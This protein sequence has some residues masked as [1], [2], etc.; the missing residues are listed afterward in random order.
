MPKDAYDPMEQNN[1]E[2]PW[3][4]IT[5][6]RPG[7]LDQPDGDLVSRANMPQVLDEDGAFC[8]D[9]TARAFSPATKVYHLCDLGTHVGACGVHENLVVFGYAALRDARSQYKCTTRSSF[10]EK[11]LFQFSCPDGATGCCTDGGPGSIGDECYY[12]TSSLCPKRRFAFLPDEA[13]PDVP[14]DSCAVGEVTLMDGTTHSYGANNDVCEDG[15]M[16]S[17]F[18]P[19]RNPCQPNTDV[20]HE[21]EPLFIHVHHTAQQK[22]RAQFV[23]PIPGERLRLA[24]AQ[25]HGARGRGALRHVQGE[26][27]SVVRRRVH[28]LHG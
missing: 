3:R 1:N 6:I 16:Y 28:G 11:Q 18:A 26:Q 9:G 23:F 14:D 7:V 25:A 27:G 8:M 17:Y 2:C 22:R 5:D 10:E 4:D 15:L 24:H 20:R 19:G 13:G 12:G 21:L